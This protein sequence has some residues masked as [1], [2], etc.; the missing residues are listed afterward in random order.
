[1]FG[2]AHQTSDGFAVRRRI[3][4]VANRHLRRMPPAVQ[5]AH[6]S[7]QDASATPDEFA[8]AH[9]LALA[10]LDAGDGVDAIEHQ[11]I[12][13][14]VSASTAADVADNAAQL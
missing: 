13:I 14:G 5:R 9:Q 4:A 1:M 7:W 8:R 2:L 3:P 12:A 6:A 10:M 11:L